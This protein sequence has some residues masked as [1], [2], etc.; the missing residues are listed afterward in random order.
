MRQRPLPFDD[1]H[2]QATSRGTCP[3]CRRGN[4]HDISSEQRAAMTV[5]TSECNVC[6]HERPRLEVEA[7]E[8][9][10]EAGK[11]GRQRTAAATNLT[12]KTAPKAALSPPGDE[13]R[14]SARMFA[15]DSDYS[16]Q[17]EKDKTPCQ[18]L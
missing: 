11:P 5:V 9:Q 16:P 4:M 10:R 7:K 3:S 14:T 6:G 15:S 12:M 17:F 13:T 18:P 2:A 8:R 1:L